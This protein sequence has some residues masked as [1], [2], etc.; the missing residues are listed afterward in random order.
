MASI[1]V[2]KHSEARKTN[3]RTAQASTTPDTAACASIFTLFIFL[4]VLI[5]VDHVKRLLS[6]TFRVGKACE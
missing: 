4:L 3:H 2:V 1:V 5:A 6:V